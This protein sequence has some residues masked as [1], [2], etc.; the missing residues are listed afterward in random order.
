MINFLRSKVFF[1][2]LLVAVVSFYSVGADRN[3]LPEFSSYSDVTQKKLAFFDYMMPLVSAGN[4]SIIEQR[5]DLLE[6]ATDADQLSFFQQRKLL[7]LAE[8]YGVDTESVENQQIIDRLLLRVA[9]LPPSLVLA[10]A[11]IESAWG[12]S[13]FARQGNNLFGQWCYQKGCGLVPLRRSAESKHEVA[14][15]DSVAAAVE[16]YLH[17]LNTHRAYKDLRI[18]RA[19]LSAAEGGANGHQLA[20]ALLYYSEL[21]QVYVDEVQAVIRINK[22]HGYD[23]L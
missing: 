10:Q 5:V 7:Q 16:A 18:L 14:K 20:Q 21:R 12:T 23:E 19:E 22:L 9:P 15:F 4:Q 6:M 2:V 1:A 13:R 8:H 11:A 3:P 17:N